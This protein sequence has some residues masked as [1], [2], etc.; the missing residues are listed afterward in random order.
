MRNH[1]LS[2]AFIWTLGILLLT[3]GCRGNAEPPANSK[4]TQANFNEIVN[5]M[6]K[7]EVKSLLGEPWKIEQS[8][9]PD[10][11]IMLDDVKVRAIYE[12]HPGDAAAKESS[13]GAEPIMIQIGF[14][15]GKVVVKRSRAIE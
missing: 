1:I 3:V 12:W 11:L 14:R 8:D 15:D 10:D 9:G 6:S 7:D 5:G 2:K 13:T 4:A